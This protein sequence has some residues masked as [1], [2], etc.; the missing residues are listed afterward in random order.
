VSKGDEL[1][2]RFHDDRIAVRAE[3]DGTV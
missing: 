2:I 3:D 1:L